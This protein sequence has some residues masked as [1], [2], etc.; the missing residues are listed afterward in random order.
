MGYPMDVE[1]TSLQLGPV[2]GTADLGLNYHC[3]LRFCSCLSPPPVPLLIDGTREQ[4]MIQDATI[5]QTD[6][7]LAACIF[8]H[9]KVS[10]KTSYFSATSIPPWDG[11]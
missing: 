2:C 3:L 8:G 10:R 11:W 4:R 1:E 6:I 7:R 5:Q 9:R